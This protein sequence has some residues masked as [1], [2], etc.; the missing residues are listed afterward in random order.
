MIAWESKVHPIPDL[1]RATDCTKNKGII[2]KDG[3]RQATS[4]KICV[5]NNLIAD[6]CDGMPY[7]LAAA[8]EAIVE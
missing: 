4:H 3:T 1:V 8:A 6:L 2:N 7:A 5:D